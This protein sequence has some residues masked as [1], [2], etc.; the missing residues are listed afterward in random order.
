MSNAI[1]ITVDGV[2]LAAR[3]GE[4]LL[5]ALRRAGAEVPTLC[6]H[7]SVEPSGAC[8]L[9]SVEIGHADWKGWTG[10]VTSC[11][12]PVEE[13]LV[14]S[15]RS[16][17][18][19]HTRR[20]LLELYLARCPDSPEIAALAR[21]EG[22][23]TTSFTPRADANLCI[24]CG[25]CV[26]VCQDLSTAAIAPLGRGTDKSVGPRP[27]GLAED[28]VGCQACEFVCPTGEISS[29]LK[30]GLLRIWKREFARP[31]CQV[32]AEHCRAC[33][34]C[35]EVCP[36]DIPRIQPRLDGTLAATISA[37]SCEGCGICAG[38]CPTGAIVQPECDDALV[39]GRDRDL[40]GKA[41]IY[42]C[43]RS[44]F[45][46][47]LP[48]DMELIPVPCVGRVGIEHMVEAMAGGADAAL[49]ICRDRESCPHGE[50]G[51]LG[52]ARARIASEL[53]ALA[54]FG[55]QRMSYLRPEP[56]PGGPARSATAWRHGVSPS[57]LNTETPCLGA[58]EPA[59][60]DRALELLR[61][62]RER[63]ELTAAAQE[64]RVQARSAESGD[65]PELA[66]LVEGLGDGIGTAL[67]KAAGRGMV[68]EP[69][70][71]RFRIDPEMRRELTA[72]MAAA[73]AGLICEDPGE[74]L[75][76]ALLTRDGAWRQGPG[77][78]P[79]LDQ[80][81]EVKA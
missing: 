65:L 2:S 61:E 14:V 43:A 25:L 67:V 39:T 30:D 23:E 1:H 36:T 28:C 55:E 81:E 29:T 66:L 31:I 8:R 12:Y 78:P 24:Q 3:P 80:P 13:G 75:Q 15:T 51:R 62:L 10:L 21:N 38:A 59:G 19:R 26:R 70:S 52:E 57:P 53:A 16:E 76:L 64:R 27:D 49:L 42:A 46:E 60:L 40:A 63:P 11:L 20:T 44:E 56:G 4:M 6:H 50:G 47:E 74:Y 32:V 79:I 5:T 71:F 18:V 72:R 37:A 68:A 45:A 77:A 7:P 34:L 58:A 73:P 22:L 54:G 9:C 41:V 33:G 17:R 69:D 35:E 48:A